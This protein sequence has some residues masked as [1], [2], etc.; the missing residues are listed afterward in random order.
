MV[1]SS[2]GMRRK[3]NEETEEERKVEV[4]KSDGGLARLDVREIDNLAAF[5]WLPFTMS[6][7]SSSLNCGR[8][9]ARMVRL[10]SKWMNSINRQHS[11]GANSQ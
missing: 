4:D 6:N 10:D 3:K 1:M 11:Y 9:R 5:T 7:Y 2:G 8:C